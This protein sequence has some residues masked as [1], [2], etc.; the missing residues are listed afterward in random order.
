M[1]FLSNDQCQSLTKE[2]AIAK[3]GASV[4]AD[5]NKVLVLERRRRRR[6]ES[7]LAAQHIGKPKVHDLKHGI[8]DLNFY[9]TKYEVDATQG[10]VKPPDT[11]VRQGLHN[12]ITFMTDH[13]ISLS[14]ERVGDLTEHNKHYLAI[15]KYADQEYMSGKE[16]T[17]G[18]TKSIMA[19]AYEA[20]S[21]MKSNTTSTTAGYIVM[22]IVL[23]LQFFL[24]ARRI[25]ALMEE[26]AGMTTLIQRLAFEAG[27]LRVDNHESHKDR[28][29]EAHANTDSSSL[30]SA[31]SA[32][33]SD[34]EEGRDLDEKSHSSSVSSASMLSEDQSL[35]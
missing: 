34:E 15:H 5:L 4:T 17:D 26:H 29:P 30:R 10:M 22:L 19:Y 8:S 20:V 21:K 27:K 7:S 16:W 3:F 12:L 24:L 28:D 13:M 11:T 6:S 9:A 1:R 25:E 14:N 23:G 2:E 35:S 33:S 32:A 18:L 31:S